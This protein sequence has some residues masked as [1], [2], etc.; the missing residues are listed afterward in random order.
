MSSF[1]K[2]SRKKSEVYQKR[3]DKKHVKAFFRILDELD[4][5]AVILK[6]KGVDITEDN[7]IDEASKYTDIT[8][9]RLEKMILLNKLGLYDYEES[10]EENN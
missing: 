3:K 8:I 2:K 7:I 1:L 9:G 10:A 5:V 6:D 4:E